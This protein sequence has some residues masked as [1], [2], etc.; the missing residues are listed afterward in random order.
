MIRVVVTVL[1]VLAFGV[2][3]AGLASRYLPIEQRGRTGRR[4]RVAVPGGR[5]A[6]WP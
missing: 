2:A 3:A 6:W 4:R 1:G 5:G